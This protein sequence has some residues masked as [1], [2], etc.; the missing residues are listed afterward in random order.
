MKFLQLRQAIESYEKN[1]VKE[2]DS[3]LKQ[4]IEFYG[5]RPKKQTLVGGMVKFRPIDRTAR[6][7][8]SKCPWW[9]KL[10]PESDKRIKL[11]AAK[12]HESKTKEQIALIEAEFANMP[13]VSI[14]GTKRWRI[15]FRSYNKQKGPHSRIVMA[16]SL[17]DAVL[18]IRYDVGASCRICSA[19]ELASENDNPTAPIKKHC[20]CCGGR[21]SNHK[22][23]GCGKRF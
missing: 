7:V 15:R 9:A 3:E 6:L 1:Q 10:L 17:E 14:K 11:M 13:P 12:M 4:N 8:V 5:P 16:D 2:P 21:I 22:C 18:A 19:E 20:N 23:K